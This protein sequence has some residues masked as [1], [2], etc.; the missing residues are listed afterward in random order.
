VLV[1]T[2]APAA[3]SVCS[4]PCQVTIA[5]MPLRLPQQPSPSNRRPKAVNALRCIQRA[6]GE[7]SRR[8]STAGRNT[9]NNPPHILKV[10]NNA[11]SQSRI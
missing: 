8:E 2:A 3:A 10:V 9:E 7:I 6:E 5:S 1:H 11:D 4:P